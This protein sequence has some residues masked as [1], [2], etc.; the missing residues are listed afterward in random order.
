M[1]DF[2]ENIVATD[3]KALSWPAGKRVVIDEKHALCVFF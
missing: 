2:I 1:L 3:V